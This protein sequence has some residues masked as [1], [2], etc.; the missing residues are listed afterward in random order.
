VGS[1]EVG[2]MGH[3][4]NVGHGTGKNA[5]RGTPVN[6]DHL[7]RFLSGEISAVETYELALDNLEP[8]SKARSNLESNLQSHK[9]RVSLLRAAIEQRGGEPAHGG[10]AWETLVKIVEDGSEP[11]GDKVA[12]T[13]LE[14][15]E[16]H[17]L[18]DYRKDLAALD[19]STRQLV[20]MQLLPKQMQ[21]LSAVSEL[22]K[23]LH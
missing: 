18:A 21:T 4:K 12:L 8:V 22:K 23:R 10:G 6:V 2:I 17:E 3:G 20:E 9:Q 13:A 14:E 16:D 5:G 1:E 7:N 11:F 19:A 15:G